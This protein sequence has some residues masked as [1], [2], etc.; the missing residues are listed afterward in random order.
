MTNIGTRSNDLGFWNSSKRS[1]ILALPP[2]Y[3]PSGQKFLRL[4]GEKNFEN[5]LKSFSF[6][7]LLSNFSRKVSL[8]ACTLGWPAQQCS[9]PASARKASRN[10]APRDSLF[11]FQ[12]VRTS[13]GHPTRVCRGRVTFLEEFCPAGLF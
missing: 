10:A 4:I 1:K 9:L 3:H 11:I 6:N 12:Y 5:I 13:R 2:A 7:S 8:G